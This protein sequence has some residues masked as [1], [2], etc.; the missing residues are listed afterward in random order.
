M[1]WA[2]NLNNK[3]TIIWTIGMLEC[4]NSKKVW[5]RSHVIFI[6]LKDSSVSNCNDCILMEG[7]AGESPK[8][9][10]SRLVCTIMDL[11]KSSWPA[12]LAFLYRWS[13]ELISV[14]RPAC[15]SGDCSDR[16]KKEIRN[17][18]TN[19]DIKMQQLNN[20]WNISPGDNE[21]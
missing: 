3:L 21:V 14:T 17:L 6:S 13:R 15:N 16:K 1:T 7:V 2:Y 9:L 19:K 18:Y 20:F 4:Y 12:S 5:R 8:L 10:I 11:G